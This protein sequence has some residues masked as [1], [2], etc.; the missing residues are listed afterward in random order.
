MALTVAIT[1]SANYIN[2]VYSNGIKINV[3]K[4]AAI[5]VQQKTVLGKDLVVLIYNDVR[6]SSSGCITLDWMNVTSPTITSANNLATVLMT[7]SSSGSYTPVVFTFTNADLVDG[8]TTFVLTRAAT[9][10]T[11]LL[12]VTI[13]DPAG[14]PTIV[15]QTWTGLSCAANFGGAIGAGNWTIKLESHA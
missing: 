4:S 5:E 10:G 1:N 2:F 12:T 8:I 14:V 15:S 9:S 7:Y 6:P 3:P 11:G 13:L